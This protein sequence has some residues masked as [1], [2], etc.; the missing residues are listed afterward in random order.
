[1][2]SLFLILEIMLRGFKEIINLNE[3][4]DFSKM[5]IMEKNN[6]VDQIFNRKKI[7]GEQK[8]NN[9]IRAIFYLK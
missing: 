3:T 8:P 4:I 5:D 1:M 7:I 2:L 6:L 9:L